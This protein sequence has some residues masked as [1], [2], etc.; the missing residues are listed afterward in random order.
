M[1]RFVHHAS[2][3][4]AEVESEFVHA[5]YVVVPALLW[6]VAIVAVVVATVLQDTPATASAQTAPPAEVSVVPLGA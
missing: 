5:R 4:I 3:R 6:A 2:S 1:S